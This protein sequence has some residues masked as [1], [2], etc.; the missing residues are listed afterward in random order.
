[1]RPPRFGGR[2]EVSPY[3]P[4]AG[5]GAPRSAGAACRYGQLRAVEAGVDREEDGAE[6]QPRGHGR[7]L[8]QPY[9]TL[10]PGCLPLASPKW[11]VAPAAAAAA[12]AAAELAALPS[13]RRRPA[14]GPFPWGP[15]PHPDF[16]TVAPPFQPSP[17][18]WPRPSS[19]A[20]CLGPAPP[21]SLPPP[22]ATPRIST[23]GLGSAGFFS[24]PDGPFF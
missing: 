4:A 8:A 21:S 12:A 6:L 15:A 13:M 22:M 23:E 16:S 10:L 5:V 9:P 20:L 24:L 19:P 3:P 1:M 2:R 11:A 18:S 14:P 7:A 17:P